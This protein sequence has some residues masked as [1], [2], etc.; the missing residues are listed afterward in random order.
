MPRSSLQKDDEIRVR[1]MLDATNEA[2]AFAEGRTREDLDR[3]RMLVLALVKC[4]EII[5]E[6]ATKIAYKTQVLFPDVPWP[7]IVTMRHRLVHA[8]YDV[9]LDRVW[10]TVTT[11]LPPLL[12]SLQSVLGTASQDNGQ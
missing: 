7:A 10:D 6:A 4:I 5:G 3:D 1:H 2:L 11:D 8:Y 12:Q 9:D